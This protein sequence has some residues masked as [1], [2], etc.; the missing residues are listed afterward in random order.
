[1]RYVLPA[2]EP[3][4]GSL[5]GSGSNRTER[6]VNGCLVSAPEFRAP[7]FIAANLPLKFKTAP[8]GL[9]FLGR[10]SICTR[11]TRAPVNKRGRRGEAARGYRRL[12]DNT[13]EHRVPLGQHRRPRIGTRKNMQFT[14]YIDSFWRSQYG[15]GYSRRDL[16]CGKEFLVFTHASCC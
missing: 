3:L 7:F 11:P 5:D 16:Q 6:P 12:E 15:A 2:K 13:E 8:M 1:M 10:I 4:R 14:Q 9:F